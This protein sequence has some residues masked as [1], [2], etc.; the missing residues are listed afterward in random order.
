MSLSDLSPRGILE[1]ELMT[2]LERL[3]WPRADPAQL[4]APSLARLGTIGPGRQ[5]W[6][7]A[8]VYLDT[9]QVRHLRDIALNNPS[10]LR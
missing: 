3:D 4:S 10:L 5:A 1:R 7:I 2:A 6:E 9:S 8:C